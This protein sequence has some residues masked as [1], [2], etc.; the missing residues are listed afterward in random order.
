MP[1]FEARRARKS[2]LRYDQATTTG[3]HRRLVEEI[4]EGVH[5]RPA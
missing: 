3:V 4:A 5:L 2:P 1:R